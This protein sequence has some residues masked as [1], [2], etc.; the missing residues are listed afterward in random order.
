[1][2]A[3]RCVN[4]AKPSGFFGRRR[5]PRSLTSRI[6]RRRKFIVLAMFCAPNTSG[7]RPSSRAHQ[8]RSIIAHMTP[9]FSACAVIGAIK[10]CRHI[11]RNEN[12]AANAM[13]A[14]TPAQ[15]CG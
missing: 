1:M 11:R 10:L 15:P 4:F 12:V 14:G 3:N 9:L 8:S 5:L 13:I 6:V 7:L 2:L